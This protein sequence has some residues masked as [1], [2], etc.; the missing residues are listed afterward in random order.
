M[1]ECQ[2]GVGR[3]NRRGE[4]S[5]AVEPRL[6]LHQMFQINYTLKRLAN[7]VEIETFKVCRDTKFETLTVCS[8]RTETFK[9]ATAIE[10]DSLHR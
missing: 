5:T 4:F 1:G 7:A 8:D 3:A 10:S 2:R 6:S 9:V